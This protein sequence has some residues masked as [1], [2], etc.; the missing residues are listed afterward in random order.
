MQGRRK[1][2]SIEARRKGRSIEISG[3][4][5]QGSGGQGL[6]RSGAQGLGAWWAIS[7][8]YLA[9]KLLLWC[10]KKA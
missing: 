10:S 7:S 4:G 5:D 8:R 1:E 3:S 6:R 2:I 9:L